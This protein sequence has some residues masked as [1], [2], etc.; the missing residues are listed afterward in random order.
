MWFVTLHVRYLMQMMNDILTEETKEGG[1]EDRI[2]TEATSDG[3]Y[4]GIALEQDDDDAE[5]ED[6]LEYIRLQKKYKMYDELLTVEE[7][8]LDEFL[9]PAHG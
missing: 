8:A 6:N 1:R 4:P 3:K 2:P 9:P 7:T 5:N